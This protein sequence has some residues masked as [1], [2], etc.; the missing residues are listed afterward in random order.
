MAA[1][2]GPV[3]YDGLTMRSSAVAVSSAVSDQKGLDVILLVILAVLVVA[4]VVRR[5]VQ[6]RNLKKRKAAST[7]Y[8]DSDVAQYG[9]GPAGFAGAASAR[10]ADG[11]SLA[12]SFEAPHPGAPGVPGPYPA[13]PPVGGT[14]PQGPGASQPLGAPS[15]AIAGL[16]TFGAPGATPPAPGARPDAP[17]AQ[18]PPAPGGPAA[19][20]LPD[21]GGD[22]NVVR[23]WD[24]ST[25]TDHTARRA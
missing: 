14:G 8:H 7:S 13:T 25:W 23:Y 2:T 22:P 20:W 9:T 17:G 18:P 1:A 24:G 12:P 11:T 10:S 6:G 16:P 4:L 19:G 5:V 15:A 3:H 21:P